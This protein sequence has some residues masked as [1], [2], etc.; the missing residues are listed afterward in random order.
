MVKVNYSTSIN[1]HTV[2]VVKA[3]TTDA[4]AQILQTLLDWSAA[5]PGQRVVVR[6]YYG[7]RVYMRH[8]ILNGQGFTGTFPRNEKLMPYRGEM[9][10]IF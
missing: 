1:G 8:I 5:H 2:K 7:D 3:T 4:E 9:V 6:C 10:V